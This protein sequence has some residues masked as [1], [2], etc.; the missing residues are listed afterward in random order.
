MT[1][2]EEGLPLLPTASSDRLYHP[3]Q[4]DIFVPDS[5]SGR[6]RTVI[7]R[8]STLTR[9]A[10]SRS[11]TALT[12]HELSVIL[13]SLGGRDLAV[14]L[15]LHHHRYL[16]TGQISAL[17]FGDLRHA[18]RRLLALADMRLIHR[19]PRSQAPRLTHLHSAALISRQGAALLAGRLGQDLRPFIRRADDAWDNCFHVDHDLEANAFFIQLARSCRDN[20]FEGLYHW[21][22]EATC[23]SIYRTRGA[24]IVPDGW[25]RYIHPLGEVSFF[26]EWDRA[27]EG[28]QRLRG[29]VGF[30][31]D[32]FL[33]RTGA[34]L[35]HVLFVVPSPTREELVSAVIRDRLPADTTC[36]FWTTNALSLDSDG[37][38]G[39][40][41]APAGEGKRFALTE[42]PGRPAAGRP[43][44]DCVGKPRWWERRPG[45]S[46]VA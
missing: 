2:M 37:S 10:S 44:E 17:F 22:G 4:A 14:L 35:K 19:W 3:S 21:L 11:T 43:V 27:T 41:W 42:L 33:G 45:G 16:H 29:K 24:R 18:Q 40:I 39:R 30:Y 46:E 26:L 28:A 36:S 34:A 25:G 15:A 5:N 1:S 13:R 6:L 8:R 9:D 7:P 12:D 38:L 23:R 31:A 20:S 32:H